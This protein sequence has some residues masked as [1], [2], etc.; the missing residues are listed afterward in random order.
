MGP[1]EIKALRLLLVGRPGEA[2]CAVHSKD[3]FRGAH[4][5]FL[6][7]HEEG[8]LC[9]VEV[10][11]KRGVYSR[12]RLAVHELH[13]IRDDPPLPEVLDRSAR[14]RPIVERHEH[15]DDRNGR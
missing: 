1:N 8:C 6:Q 3:L 14:R 12:D 10:R 9:L 2:S 5:R 11:V 15:P 4:K 7:L 13:E